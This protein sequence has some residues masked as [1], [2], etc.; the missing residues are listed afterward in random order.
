[1]PPIFGPLYCPL[2]LF[3]YLK[4]KFFPY[5]FGRFLQDGDDAA[6]AAGLNVGFTSA[7]SSHTLSGG[8]LDDSE[9][10]FPFRPTPPLTSPFDDHFQPP[11]SCKRKALLI[12]VEDNNGLPTKRG[13]RGPHK[14]IRDMH[15]FLLGESKFSSIKHFEFTIS[16]SDRKL[17]EPDDIFVLMNTNDPKRVQPTRK[18]IV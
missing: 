13:L 8:N 2:E 10:H 7:G 9:P 3:F 15:Q 11:R 12:G 5:L 16:L 18:N 4:R 17:Y 6:A 14:D 1:M